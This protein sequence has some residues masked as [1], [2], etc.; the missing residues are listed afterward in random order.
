ME[1][2]ESVRG[3]SEGRNQFRT[4]GRECMNA[5]GTGKTEWD[6]RD[7]LLSILFMPIKYFTVDLYMQMPR[8]EK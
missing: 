7:F 6:T 4:K 8:R 2:I 5:K 1:N 3:N